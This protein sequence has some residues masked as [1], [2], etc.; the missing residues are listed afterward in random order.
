MKQQTFTT[1]QLILFWCIL[2]FFSYIINLQRVN[3]LSLS[4]LL[5]IIFVILSGLAMYIGILIFFRFY[6][7]FA[8]EIQRT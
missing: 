6:P 3:S 4:F 2:E 5:S 7:N 1:K 8:E